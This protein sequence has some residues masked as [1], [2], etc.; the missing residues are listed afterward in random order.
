MSAAPDLVYYSIALPTPATTTVLVSGVSSNTISANYSTLLGNQPSTYGNTAFLWQSGNSI[1]FNQTPLA[2][3]SIPG[4]TEDGS[5]GFSGLTIQS[6]SYILGYAVGPDI[7][8]ICATCYIP[9][10]GSDFQTFQT[11]LDVSNVSTDSATVNYQTP[12]GYSPQTNANYIGLWEGSV[13]SYTILP[14]IK[15]NITSNSST[16]SVVINNFQ[17]KRSTTYTLAYFMGAKQV[18]MAAT[19]TFST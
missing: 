7:S 5:F 17:F 8:Q 9:A 4:N 13:A 14:L 6:K 16:G 1:P 18:Y 3:Y 2:T 10:S 11:M 19:Y 12:A 15:Q